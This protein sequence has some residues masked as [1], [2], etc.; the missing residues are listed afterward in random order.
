MPERTRPAAFTA[1]FA[2]VAERNVQH[3]TLAA[4]H[5]IEPERLADTLDPFSRRCGTQP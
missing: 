3:A 5:G 4:V 1:Q 2:F